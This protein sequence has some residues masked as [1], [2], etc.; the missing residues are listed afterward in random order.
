MGCRACADACPVGAL[1]HSP[2]AHGFAAVCIDEEKCIDCGRCQRA[3]PLVAKPGRQA[4][5]AR[6]PRAYA[7]YHT[8]QDIRVESTSGG[9]YYALAEVAIARG[10][11]LAGCAYTEDYSA[12]RHILAEGYAG[13]KKIM[14]SKYFQSDTT[15]IY[16]AVEQRLKAGEGVLFC[17][18]PCQVA[19]LYR[20]LG[21]EY[22]ELYTVDFICRGINSPAAYAAFVRELLE[23]YGPIREVRFKDKSHGWTRLGTRVI[24]ADGTERYWDRFNDPW[25]NG[26]VAFNLYLRPACAT[27]EFKEF[28][29]HSDITIG[30]FWGIELTA[31]ERERG[32]SLALVNNARGKEMLDSAVAAG[33]LSAREDT[34]A[35][36]VNGNPALLHPAPRST[37]SA[38]FFSLLETGVPYSEAVW[39]AAGLGF[40][41][42]HLREARMRLADKLHLLKAYL[43]GRLRHG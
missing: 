19:A 41:L 27:C 6:E 4:G 1:T 32:L 43:K 39:R 14:R 35:R 36:A 34:L 10:Y 40:P 25:V 17:G 15:G 3:C 20:Y 23:R 24:F 28:P 37:R 11:A 29:R 9:L 5:N 22:D 2:D 42:Y 12:A 33:H 8:D 13:L 26:F 30:D 21:R 38:E 7:V 18:C 16:K 31:E